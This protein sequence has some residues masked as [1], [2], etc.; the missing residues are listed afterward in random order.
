MSRDL[1]ISAEIYI[2]TLRG[3]VEEIKENPNPLKSLI[4]EHLIGNERRSG[5]TCGTTYWITPV[6]HEAADAESAPMPLA[7]PCLVPRHG[8]GQKGEGCEGGL[9][10]HTSGQ[11]NRGPTDPGFHERWRVLECLS[12]AL[13]HTP[14]TQLRGTTRPYSQRGGWHY[15]QRPSG[16]N[17][18]GAKR[19]RPVPGEH[20]IGR[21]GSQDGGRARGAGSFDGNGRL[22]P[23]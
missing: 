23:Y 17:A 18:A 14:G 7:M 8:G 13:A 4:R 6:R 16:E 12:R 1:K 22:F 10:I 5:G 9:V 19:G 11:M 15:W 3:W 21:K 20:S 2:E